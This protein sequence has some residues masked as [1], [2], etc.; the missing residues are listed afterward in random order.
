L[1]RDQDLLTEL[2]RL[3]A[4]FD[5]E[6]Y[7]SLASRG[8]LRR[9]RKE[10]DKGLPI[11]LAGIEGVEAVV[12][13]GEHR[14]R[15]PVAGPAQAQCSCP[16]TATCQHILAA[17]LQL[18]ELVGPVA[19]GLEQEEG[20]PP[21]P[22]A[23]RWL[24]LDARSFRRWAG[25]EACRR[26]CR[27]LVDHAPEVLEEGQVTVRFNTGVVCHLPPTGDLGGIITKA[28]PRLHRA[29]AVAAVLA[30]QR[31]HGISVTAQ[32]E[33]GQGADTSLLPVIQEIVEEVVE[34]GLNH[35]SRGAIARLQA[36]AVQCRGARLY[37]PALE[38]ESCVQDMEWL[39]DRHA[40][41]STERLFNRLARLYGLAEA[42]RHHG[43]GAP[44]QLTGLGRS[45][46]LE[47]AQLAL[48]GLG[49]YPWET[50]SGYHGLTALFLSPDER[51]FF[52]WSEV[53]PLESADGFDP[54]RRFKG[55]APWASGTSLRALATQAFTLQHP[56]V[57][58]QRRLGSREGCRA[59]DLRPLSVGDVEAVGST[60]FRSWRRL[61]EAQHDARRIGLWRGVPLDGAVVVC[62]Q[63][64][65]ER[66]F[67]QISQAFHLE[68]HDDQG[69]RMFVTLPFAPLTERA[70]GFLE[71]FKPA[72]GATMLLAMYR[73]SPHEHL[74]PVSL[75]ELRANGVLI[76]CMHFVEASAGRRVLRTVTGL[77]RS[78]LPA[79]LIA[80]PGD[81][82]E[83][84]PEKELGPMA[85]LLSPVQND[86][87][88]LAERGSHRSTGVQ[89]GGWDAHATHLE[90]VGLLRLSR[91][92]RRIDDSAPHGARRLL[93]ARYLALLHID[94]A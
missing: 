14:V 16:A 49:A 64:W 44:A 19:G 79:R 50:D 3:L 43:D 70:I 26:A 22:S 91:A 63:R 37:R 55:E 28:A 36:L 58:E 57:N 45:R 81:D 27:L 62:P 47:R 13:V 85:H 46:Y 51:A 80:A 42:L 53:R 1:D 87:L 29:Y 41:A 89:D 76:T 75:I 21:E 38:M 69:D 9:A 12:S 86:L 32:A 92:L 77:I 74:W 11:A 66:H 39:L 72:D 40:R 65:G 35:V 54:L 59:T 7:E 94:A 93:A 82:E 10:I 68:L 83:E 61:K 5:D 15:L 60:V 48:L 73:T 56:H 71:T 18:P 88:H 90:R 23:A 2:V 24:A 4:S 78:R 25:A 20:S 34:A 30:L 6:A 31:S 8:L 33:T 84:A 52:S 67:D 17:C